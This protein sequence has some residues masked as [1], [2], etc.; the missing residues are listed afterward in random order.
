MRRA[1]RQLLIALWSLGESSSLHPGATDATVTLRTGSLK[2]STISFGLMV[3]RGT[4]ASYGS[5]SSPFI[6][7]ASLGCYRLEQISVFSLGKNATEAET[8]PPAAENDYADLRC[9]FETA[10]LACRWHIH[11]L[12]K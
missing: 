8:S 4:A 1:L 5:R 6:E 12:T 11:V 2:G 9:W 10:R 3:L 7:T